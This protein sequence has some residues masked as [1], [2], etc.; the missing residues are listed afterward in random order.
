MLAGPTDRRVYGGIGRVALLAVLYACQ[1]NE[2]V[3]TKEVPNLTVANVTP[4]VASKLDAGGH[5]LLAHGPLDPTRPE[6]DQQTAKRLGAAFMKTFGG[7][8]R[9]LIEK[10]RGV[11]VHLNDLV[12]CERAFYAAS[13]YEP[14]ALAK[15]I[16]GRGR[17]RRRR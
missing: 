15:T 5:F 4:S 3:L 16:G 2:T 10:D 1:G 14:T 13:A 11:P 9:T 7:W 6:I 17:P 8:V 12:P